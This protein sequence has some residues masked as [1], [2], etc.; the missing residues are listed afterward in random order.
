MEIFFLYELRVLL[1]IMQKCILN[2]LA[3]VI[4]LIVVMPRRRVLYALTVNIYIS[5]FLFISLLFNCS[6]FNGVIFFNV[7]CEELSWC[8]L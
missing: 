4:G 6:F 8:F 2:T 5:F 7:L 1:F 3:S